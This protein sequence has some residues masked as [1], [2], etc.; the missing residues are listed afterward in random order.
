M[1]SPLLLSVVVVAA[2]AFAGVYDDC[3]FLFRGTYPWKS[4]AAEKAVAEEFAN[5][6]IVG[7]GTPDTESVWGVAG[8]KREYVNHLLTDVACPFAGRVLK[9]RNVL[10]LA[11]H[12]YVNGS[13]VLCGYSNRVQ[14]YAPFSSNFT[15]AYSIVLRYRHDGKMSDSSTETCLF[16]FGYSWSNNRGMSVYLRGEDD[17]QYLYIMQ[18]SAYNVEFKL[19]QNSEDTKLRARK[20]VDL[21]ICRNNDMPPTDT[22]LCLYTCVEG[23]KWCKQTGRAYGSPAKDAAVGNLVMLSTGADSAT[24]SCNGND[25]VPV[26]D[27]SMKDKF[28]GAIQKFAMWRR[29]LS[30]DEVKAA[31]CEDLADG[32]V[33]RLGAANDSTL[34]FAGV[35][36]TT[37]AAVTETD[38]DESTDWRYFN[39]KL[40]SANPTATVR[41]S[42]ANATGLVAARALGVKATSDSVASAR[43]SASLNG[44]TLVESGELA[45]GGTLRAD[46]P[47]TALKVGGNVLTL[48]R[49]DGGTDALRI[50]ALSVG[51]AADIPVEPQVVAGDVYSGALG[52][53]RHAVDVNGDGWW[54]NM[55]GYPNALLARDEF[56]NTNPPDPSEYWGRTEAENYQVHMLDVT[57]PASGEVLK[58]EGCVYFRTLTWEDESGATNNA[59]GAI[60]RDTTQILGNPSNYTILARMKIEELVNPISLSLLGVGLTGNKG[61][62]LDLRPENGDMNNL[63][64]Y[65]WRGKGCSSYAATLTDEKNHLAVGKW[66]DYALTVSNHVVRLYTF[67]EGG[68]RLVEQATGSTENLDKM[69][70]VNVCIGYMGAANT[71]HSA[72][73]SGLPS[74][75]RG[76]LHNAAVWGRALNRDE[77]LKA[78]MW[79]RPDVVR[80]GVADKTANE[81]ANATVSSYTVPANADFEAGSPAT[82]GPGGSYT[83]TFDLPASERN[84]NQLFRMSAL[85]AGTTQPIG[86]TV[87]GLV[88]T[89]FSDAGVASCRFAPDEDGFYEAG[90][91]RKWLK[92]GVNTVT[93]FV[94]SNA[95]SAVRVDSLVVGNGG[96]RVRVNTGDGMVI[97]VR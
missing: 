36:A 83:V 26:T 27:S 86:V 81:F 28:R 20:W 66:I 42:V 48:T 52:W 65:V 57:N 2:S 31:F 44:V 37:G 69:T 58:N 79:P 96:E 56:R 11:Q 40:T 76:W 29:K 75:F 34:E 82:I 72:P 33:L 5:A 80:L 95:T 7:K 32:D 71:K 74:A 10:Y 93:V 35:N 24:Q 18:G 53:W 62:G 12:T 63:R 87:N 92:D 22:S 61:V 41:F 85:D 3:P 54:S 67:V 68:T 90:I 55:K 49:T 50:D 23:G 45:A 1:K 97:L 13:G 16:N 39:A 51:D 77:I 64:P 30:D 73:G 70:S 59:Y 38:A 84:R 91:S 14:F 89:N 4:T 46:V 19:T 6:M 60:Y 9:N 88:V 47:W 8:A 21:A 15:N 25:N 43:V 94:D 17:N 78:M